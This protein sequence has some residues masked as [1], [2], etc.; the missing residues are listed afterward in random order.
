ME[1]TAN[2]RADRKLEKTTTTLSAALTFKDQDIC[3][4]QLGWIQLF[5]SRHG[6]LWL[7][8]RP[9][10]N[11]MFVSLHIVCTFISVRQPLPPF[12][13][14]RLI[15]FW[16][17]WNVFAVQ[18]NA[19]VLYLLTEHTIP[20]L[21]TRVLWFNRKLDLVDLD[22]IISSLLVISHRYGSASCCDNMFKM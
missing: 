8:W 9:G 5:A 20:R 17:F 6:P 19:F 14:D 3:T 2:C 22:Y 18:R 11:E 4:P 13:L 16:M 1:A 7:W 12:P 21:H 10:S 15:H